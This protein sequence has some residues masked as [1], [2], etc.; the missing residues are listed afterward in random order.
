MIK[1]STYSVYAHVRIIV[2]D[3]QFTKNPLKV[4]YLWESGY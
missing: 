3:P 2:K 4:I 1:Y